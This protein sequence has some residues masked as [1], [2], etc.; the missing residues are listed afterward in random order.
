MA[1]VPASGVLP[2]DCDGA[3]TVDL[4]GLGYLISTASVVL[5]G[6]VAWPKPDEPHWKAVILVVG[7]A[8]SV[9]GMGVRFMSHRKEQAAIA[10]AQREAERANGRAA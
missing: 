9:I 1:P 10:Y 3:F 8:A 6:A 7:M 5:L 2:P 4:K